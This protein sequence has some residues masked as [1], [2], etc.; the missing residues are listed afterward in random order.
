MKSHRLLRVTA[1]AALGVLA[2]ILYADFRSVHQIYRIRQ[3]T[4]NAAPDAGTRQALAAD[5]DKWDREERRHKLFV[6]TGLALD[7]AVLAWMLV[8][9]LRSPRHL[10]SGSQGGANPVAM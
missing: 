5:R 3:A 9:V 10:H 8:G 7:L 4:I 6:G 2:I 1:M